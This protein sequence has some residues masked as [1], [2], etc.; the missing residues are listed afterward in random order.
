MASIAFS[1]ESTNDINC[2]VVYLFFLALHFLLLKYCFFCFIPIFIGLLIHIL[3]LDFYHY[4]SL[5][6][7]IVDCSVFDLFSLISN[8]T[9]SILHFVD[10]T[11]HL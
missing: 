2:F 6:F 11:L 3:S 8:R 4:H 5:L 10:I 7:I 9:Q 1:F